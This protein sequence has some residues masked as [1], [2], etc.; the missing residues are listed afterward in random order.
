MELTQHE[1]TWKSLVH[2]DCMPNVW[3]KLQPILNGG[4]DRYE[5]AYR[6]RNKANQYIWHIDSGEVLERD[7]SGMAT[8]MEGCDMP[9]A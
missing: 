2:K 7:A 4:E 1:D 3:K 5:C 6:L 8:L 9:I